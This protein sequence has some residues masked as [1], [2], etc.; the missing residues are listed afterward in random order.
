M[1]LDFVPTLF[2]I[3]AARLG[4]FAGEKAGREIPE[5]MREIA[6]WPEDQAAPEPPSRAS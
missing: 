6:A 3:R 5:Y 2:Q 4:V 1:A